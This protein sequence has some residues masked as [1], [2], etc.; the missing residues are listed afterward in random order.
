[1]RK[2]SARFR[3]YIQWYPFS[4]LNNASWALLESEHYYN[5]FIKDGAFILSYRM[6]YVTRGYIQK[7]GA[8][9]RD[10]HLVAPVTYLYLLAVGVE[11]EK[12]YVEARPEMVCLYAGDIGKRE[13]HYRK[14]YKVYCDAV[15][16][17]SELYDYC[18]RTDVSNFYGSINVD[19]LLS[20][21]QDYSWN[22]LA[23]SDCLFLRGLLL[24]CGKGRF[25]VIQNHPTLSFLATKVY[26][27]RIDLELFE[28]LR[29]MSNIA[30]F[31]L[32]RYV[33]DMYVFFNLD[34]ESKLLNEQHSIANVYSDLLRSQGLSLNQNKLSFM[35]AQEARNSLAT[36]S[37]VDFSGDEIDSEIRFDSK[38]IE[39][40]LVALARSIDEGSYTH[41]AFQD[42]IAQGFSD[43][44]STIEPMAAFRQ[45]LF[46]QQSLFKDAAVINALK[47]VLMPGNVVLSYNTAAMV[48]CMLNTRDEALIKNLLNNLF[49]SARAGT[50]SGLDSLIALTYLQQRSMANQDLINCLKEVEPGLAKYCIEYCK[51]DF[52]TLFPTEEE[53]KIILI[54]HGDEKSKTQYIFSLFHSASGNEL[55]SAAYYRSFFDRFTSFVNSRVLGRR[56][57]WLYKTSDLMKVYEQ[58]NS[59]KDIINAAEK[60]RQDNPLI[61]ASSKVIDSPSYKDDLVQ[62]KR[63]LRKLIREY[64]EAIDLDSL[65]SV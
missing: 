59:S 43:E 1:M 44:R 42:A 35:L 47:S 60:M 39:R 51:A 3:S 18:I 19:A 62:M 23:A 14:S 37:V 2:E 26:L 5:R 6:R 46:W 53:A 31:E 20:A 30:S 4:Q 57:K 52:T 17:C 65:Q 21:M 27:S 25:P 55:E 15:A 56:H 24:Y 38:Q 50:W 41:D 54:L 40:F 12:T 34:D 48:Q 32:V 33:D 13:A 64:L 36:V 22:R 10:S 7:Q 45:C 29:R 16:H 63:S 61:H 28:R 58:V 49:R 9:M 8:T 11:Y